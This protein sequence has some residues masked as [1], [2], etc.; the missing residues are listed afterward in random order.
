VHQIDFD[1]ISFSSLM[2]DNK[3]I[4]TVELLAGWRHLPQDEM[5]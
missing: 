2:I 1:K 5:F 4:D 3:K